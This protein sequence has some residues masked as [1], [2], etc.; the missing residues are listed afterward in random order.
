MNYFLPARKILGISI[1]LIFLFHSGFSQSLR[2]TDT[3]YVNLGND[4]SL[5][6]TNFTIEAWIKIESPGS[7]T[8]T[9]AGGIIAVP[10]VTKGRAQLESEALDVNYFLGYRPSDMRLVADFEDNAGSV[11]HPVVS[12]GT[13]SLCIWTHVAASYD[14][15]SRTWKLYLNGALNT[16]LVLASTFTPQSGSDISACIGSSLNTAAT[17][18]PGYF[19]GRIDEVRIW[20]V[21]RTDADILANYNTELTSGT[22]LAGR[23]GLNEGTGNTA[24][25]SVNPSA[26][27]TIVRNP[28]WVSAFNVA[29]PT[30]NAA[31]DFNGVHDYV[32]FGAA[33]GLN[34]GSSFTLEGW[35]KIDGPGVT[36]STGTTGVTAVPV[37]AKGRGESETGN[38]NMNYFLGIDASNK[39]VA[40]FEEF[41]GPNHPAFGN[42]IIPTGVWTHIAATYGAGTWILYINGV[43]DI[44]ELETGPGPVTGSTQHASIGSALTSMGVPAGFFNGKI[45]EVRIWNTVRTPAEI[46]ANYTNEITSGTGLLGRWGF[47]ENC[48]TTISNSV[49]SIH[50][51]ATVLPTGN[52][53]FSNGGLVWYSG[54]FNPAPAQPSSPNPADNGNSPGISPQLCATVNDP[55]GGNNLRVRYYGRIKNTNTNRFTVIWL[56]DTQYYTEEPQPHPSHGGTNAIFKTQTNW[57]VSKKDSLNIVYVGQLGDCVEH[58]DNGGNDIEWRRA[59]TSFKIIEDP[60]TTSLPQGI[61][62]GIAVGNHDQGPTGNGDPNG[63]TTFYNQYFGEARFTGRGYYGG[64]YGTNNDNHYE[65]FS[66]SGVDFISI[67]FEFDQAAT[68]NTAVLNWADNLLKTHPNRKG[69][70]YAHYLLN[71]NGTFSV[72]GAH[73]YNA[74]KDNPNLILMVCGHVTDE[75]RRSDPGDDGH[76]IHTVM[77]DYQGRAQGGTGWLRIFQFDP[78]MNKIFVKT[79]SPWLGIYE[80]DADSSSRFTLNTNLGGTFTLIGENTNVTSGSQSC[81]TWSGLSFDTQYE[82][83]VELFDGENTT[84]GPLW[85]FLTPSGAPLPVS[86]LDIKATPE[87]KKVKLS[88]KTTTEINSKHFEVEHSSNG[89]NF[90][91]IATVLAAGNS[92]TLNQYTA[93]DE[94]PVKGK[95]Y[96]RLKMVDRDNKFEYSKIVSADFKNRM[97]KVEIFPNP[98]SGNLVR[99]NFNDPAGSSALVQVY[100]NSG[101]LR[102][103][104]NVSIQN[105][106]IE[107][108]HKLPPGSYTLKITTPTIN[109]SSKIVIK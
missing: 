85:S 82:W 68:A 103:N 4:A 58:G 101:R 78:S 42:A 53:T 81:V 104:K 24:T 91:G 41:S 31:I 76:I 20:N 49:G 90:K 11:N 30:T 66:A 48:N 89:I 71:L 57:I 88:W 107:L 54:G 86:L 109:E 108:V 21:A 32:T 62:Y 9:G 73:V 94:L 12:T 87:N 98:V 7:T 23:W 16:T 56:P 8:E 96:Y 100:D 47:N 5:K 92:T 83:Y 28:Q 72:Q 43:Q 97:G 105:N 37:I 3:S 34:T 65:L 93:Y 102:M 64:H 1:F 51:T 22:G 59:D 29:D 35:I 18:R 36:T 46:Q 26:N 25:N 13:L 79:Y 19:N 69:I 10:I 70:I 14:V 40:D 39:L 27:G 61:P 60:V 38:L 55:N 45:D 2:F 15:P 6:L 75:A 50:G 95:N 63:T 77:S 80:E 74:L 17:N 33:A 44:T 52:S 106:S 84:T 99:I 67:S